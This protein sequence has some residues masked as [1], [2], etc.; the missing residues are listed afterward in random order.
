MRSENKLNSGPWESGSA[1]DNNFLFPKPSVPFQI[2]FPAPLVPPALGHHSLAFHRGSGWLDPEV[3]LLFLYP[4]APTPTPESREG[5][6]VGMSEK[7]GSGPVLLLP[8][9]V[10]MFLYLSEL[11]F[12]N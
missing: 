2:F 4:V 12:S 7:P 3:S 5:S 8:D 9:R 11:C 10:V 1:L 6:G